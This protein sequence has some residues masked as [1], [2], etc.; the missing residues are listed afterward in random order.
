MVSNVV[1]FSVF[2]LEEIPLE[3]LCGGVCPELK[4]HTFLKFMLAFPYFS[5]VFRHKRQKSTY[6]SRPVRKRYLIS[7]Q[8][9]M[10]KV[11]AL[12]Q[13]ENDSQLYFWAEHTFIANMCCARNPGCNPR[14]FQTLYTLRNQRIS[15]FPH[16]DLQ[17]H[18]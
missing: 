11:F 6:F 5:P 9:K 12:R 2:C 15:Y 4:Q 17:V 18:L 10:V 1:S 16:Y 3:I 13:T 8:I 14:V 7:N